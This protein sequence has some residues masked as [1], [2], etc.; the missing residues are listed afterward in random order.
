VARSLSQEERAAALA[1]FVG[2]TL[3]LKVIEVD[4]KRRRLVLSQREAERAYRRQRKRELLETLEIGQVLEGQVTSLRDFGA[5]VDIGGADGLLHVS[6]ISHGRVNHPREVLS[7]GQEIRV[8]VVRLDR[9]RGRIGLS[10]RRLQPNPWETVHQKFYPGQLVEARIT[11]V[12]NFG[13]FAELEPGIEGLIHVSRLGD[14]HVGSPEDVVSIDDW[15]MTRVLHIDAQQQRISLS[16]KDVPQWVEEP[17]EA[18][19]SDEPGDATASPE[20]LTPD[21]SSQVAESDE[22]IMSDKPDQAVASDE[23]AV[24]EAAAVETSP[25]IDQVVSPDWERI[26]S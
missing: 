11:N 7:V 22:V 18:T 12:V 4:R 14:G 17:V 10:M 1:A 2:Q 23:P 8:A 21:E 20:V 24:D 25:P 15:V 16:L 13:A 19:G 26:P 5:F 9:E 6:E 3:R